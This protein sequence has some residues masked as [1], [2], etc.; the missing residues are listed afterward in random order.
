MLRELTENPA[1]KPL[2]YLTHEDIRAIPEF[3]SQALI[4][5]KVTRAT[6]TTSR[7]EHVRNNFLYFDLKANWDVVTHSH[8]THS[9]C[10]AAHF[11]SLTDISLLTYSPDRNNPKFRPRLEPLW[12]YPTL[13]RACLH[14]NAAIRYGYAHRQVLHFSPIHPIC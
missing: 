5:I 10:Y 9:P 4:A 7:F 6:R 14:R 12:K 3:R 8:T 13:T 11:V 1:H 2:A